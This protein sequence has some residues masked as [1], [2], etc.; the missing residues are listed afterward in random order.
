[1]KV[2][3]PD[4]YCCPEAP[5]RFDQYVQKRCFSDPLPPDGDD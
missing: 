4:V 1:M 5:I 3:I 2:G